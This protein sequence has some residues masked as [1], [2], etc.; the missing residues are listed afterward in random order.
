MASRRSGLGSSS[1]VPGAAVVVTL[2][3]AT[4]PSVAQ[5]ACV[6][7]HD[8]IFT[9]PVHE[10]FACADCHGDVDPETHPETVPEMTGTEI[11]AQCHDL[12]AGLTEGPHQEI[13]CTDCHGA[14][15]EVPFVGR[16]EG[17]LAPAHQIETCG[18]CHDEP[19]LMNGYLA[20]VHA[21]ALLVSG[22][23]DAPSCSDCHG[24]HDIFPPDDPRA[25]VS[26]LQVPETCGSCHLLILDT[27]R[28]QSAH[29]LAWKDGD[30]EVPVCTTCHSSHEIVPPREAAAR[31]ESPESCGKCHEE[32]FETYRD[33]FHGQATNLG[34]RTAAVCADCHTPHQNLAASDPRSSIH[35]DNLQTTCGKCHEEVTAAFV[36]FDPHSDPTD[37]EDHRAVYRVWWLMTALLVGVF[38]FFGL[39]A[40]L[41]LQRSLVALARGE[42]GPSTTGEGPHVRRFTPL[43]VWLHVVVVVTFLV[44]AATGLPLKFHTADW[45]QT[46]AMFMGGVDATRFLHRLAALL[47]FGYFL[48]H[49]ANVLRRAALD[50]EKGLFWG[51]KSMVPRGKDLADLWG[52]LRYFVYAGKKPRLDRFTYWEKFD[53]FAVFWGVV[54]IGVS[55]L[56][57]WF[58]AFFVRFLPGWGLN[59][60]HVIHSDEALLAVGFIFVFHFFHTHLRPESFPM[61]PVI[62][63]GSMPLERFKEERPVE[64]E[65]LAASGELERRL[66]DPP[67][68]QALAKARIFGF[69]AVAI[70]L[71]LVVGIL[72]AML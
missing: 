46:L 37:P 38:G 21:R 33:T 35:P 20:S 53:Y 51:W 40:A 48:F 59:A 16:L 32:A 70:G 23:V 11:C 66:V 34:F 69:A 71:L 52:N 42:L 6:E 27:W 19:E 56:A 63:T 55:G 29:G 54:I 45:A 2:W 5:E 24:S 25:T 26:S 41:W 9:S 72:G 43:Q 22:L 13:T 3:M 65:R 36:S 12:G 64:Y 14:A 7:C 50:K 1:W 31:R 10:G 49:V 4:M 17:P 15:H 39:H 60:A 28:D 30:E 61:D 58:P 47:T 18:G 44:L 57:L 62:F 68:R 67:T 8:E